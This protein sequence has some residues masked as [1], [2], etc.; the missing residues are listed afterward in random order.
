MDSPFLRQ[1]KHPISVRVSIKCRQSLRTVFAAVVG[2][3]F[4]QSRWQCYPRPGQPAAVRQG[5]F[6]PCFFRGEDHIVPGK[7]EHV[8]IELCNFSLASNFTRLRSV[9][10]FQRQISRHSRTASRYQLPLPTRRGCIRRDGIAQ[11][12]YF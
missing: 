4:G 9:P 8:I 6:V 12:L 10:S 5:C 2:R 1:T 11:F 7:G 3:Q